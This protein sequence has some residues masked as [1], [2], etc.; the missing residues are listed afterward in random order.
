MKTEENFISI[1]TE[2]VEVNKSQ[3]IRMER[4]QKE[5]IVFLNTEAKSQTDKN[6]I[7]DEIKKLRRFMIELE[8][9]VQNIG[10]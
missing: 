3:I 7:M 5:L 1:S 8:Y 9:K 4:Y 2:P 6:R 10:L